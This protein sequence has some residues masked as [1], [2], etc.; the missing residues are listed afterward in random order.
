MQWK[1]LFQ[2]LSGKTIQEIAQSFSVAHKRTLHQ[3]RWSCVQGCGWRR[4]MCVCVHFAGQEAPQ[5]GP[6]KPVLRALRSSII[7]RGRLS[8]NM[9]YGWL[10]E[11][12]CDAGCTRCH[13][14]SVVH[15]WAEHFYQYLCRDVNFQGQCSRKFAVCKEYTAKREEQ[16]PAR[17]AMTGM[18][19]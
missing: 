19:M 6:N 16:V 5:A 17:C 14:P 4:W 9:D 10:K 3:M 11:Q 18:F 1:V 7:K 8:G 2:H 12:E 13:L 15:A